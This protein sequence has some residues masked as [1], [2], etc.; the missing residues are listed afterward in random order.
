MKPFLRPIQMMIFKVIFQIL[1]FNTIS[2][3]YQNKNQTWWQIINRCVQRIFLIERKILV[4]DFKASLWFG[5]RKSFFKVVLNK[6]YLWHLLLYVS[7]GGETE[8]IYEVTIISILC[9]TDYERH[10]NLEAL[11]CSWGRG[12]LARSPRIWNWWRSR[13]C[14][15]PSSSSYASSFSSA[16]YSF[17]GRD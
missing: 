3:K 7:W 17:F 16:S 12:C 1:N 2:F 8:G 6:C 10:Y 11:T 9:T 5:Y 14:P 15:C 13:V 4:G